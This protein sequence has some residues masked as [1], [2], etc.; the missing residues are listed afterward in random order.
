MRTRTEGA[1]ARGEN[2][3]TTLLHIDAS[4]RREGSLSRRLSK[5][6]IEA[7]LTERPG[8][9]VLRRDVGLEP[10]PFVTE[11][12]IAAAFTKPADRTSA[13]NRVLAPSDL[14]I[15][16]IERADVIV[17]GTPMYNYGMPAQLK[18]WIDQVV[19]I[20]RTFSFDLGRGEWPLE[21]IL[22]GKHL[23]LLTASGEFGFEEGGIRQTMNHLD[24]HIRTCSHYLGASHLY[25]IA[26][27]YQ[28]FG[29]NR[30][31][32]SVAEAH[33]AVPGMVRQVIAGLASS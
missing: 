20:D 29:G 32:N 30:H 13:M 24:P 27:A 7:W 4:V 1:R 5:A 21:P 14:Y 6:F 22:S 19:R 33:V 17:L 28:E 25:H 10:P 11:N 26:I 3:V 16:E 31:E 15:S 2:P 23:V 8:D 12:W 9:S 18:A